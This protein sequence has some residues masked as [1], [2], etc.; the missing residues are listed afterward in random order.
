MKTLHAILSW[1]E[2]VSLL[3]PLAFM[4]PVK[5]QPK[6]LKPVRLYVWAALFLNL[7]ISIIFH[8]KR[9]WHFP[10]EL[11]S[12]NFLYNA[13]SVVRM[14]LFAWFFILVKQ[15]FLKGLKKV[16]PFLF[17]VFL[18]INFLFFEDFFYYWSLSGRLHS[19]EVSL[20]LM[21][22]LQYYFFILNE[23]RH[24]DKRPPSFWIVTGLSIYVVINFPIF[25]FYKAMVKE[26]N[27]FAIN[28]WDIQNISYIVFCIF[29][30]KAFYDSKTNHLHNLS[31][32]T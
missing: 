32:Q 16:V 9:K 8:Y 10:Q 11:M 26:F 25:L 15:R 12:N 4:Y 7:A 17:I 24:D 3:I 1:S 22:C 18:A 30:A 20:L 23:D 13:N 28:I 14:L 19:L 31:N 5:N 27:K 21:Y 2:V 6:Y 29:L